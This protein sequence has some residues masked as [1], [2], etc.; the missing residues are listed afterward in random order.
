MRDIK[1]KEKIPP[2]RKNRRFSNIEKQKLLSRTT[3]ADR[4]E[5]ERSLSSENSGEVGKRD[6]VR[7]QGGYSAGK[8]V[9]RRMHTLNFRKKGMG[10]RIRREGKWLRTVQNEAGKD[11][12]ADEKKPKTGKT[13]GKVCR[14]NCESGYPADPEG[15][16]GCGKDNPESVNGNR[17]RRVDCFGSTC[18]FL[19]GCSSDCRHRIFHPRGMGVLPFRER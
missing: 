5:Q 17:L 18:N 3:D 7:G 15:G 11:G 9:A 13:G 16:P 4:S 1:K 8:S 12:P 10:K 6:E 2:K 14:E 19:R